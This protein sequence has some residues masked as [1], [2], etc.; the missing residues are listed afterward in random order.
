MGEFTQCQLPNGKPTVPRK[1]LMSWEPEPACR[2][3]KMYQGTRYR[4]NCSELGATVRTKEGSGALA[5]AWWRAKLAELTTGGRPDS[6]QQ[7]VD[8]LRA[9]GVPGLEK[10][11]KRGDVAVRVLASMDGIG[12]IPSSKVTPQQVADFI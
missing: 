8:R 11:Y 7:L 9:V 3:V 10:A 5:D 4:V 6:L 1:Y 2:W 12:F